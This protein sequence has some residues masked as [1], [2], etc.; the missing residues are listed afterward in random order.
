[1]ADAWRPTSALEERL[2]DAVA[3]GDQEGYFRALAGAELVVPVAPEVVDG[4]LGGGARPTWPTHE[5]DGRVYALVY[6][7]AAAMRAC[8]GDGYRHFLT[9]TFQDLAQS[10]P[11]NAWWLAVDVPA[12]SSPGVAPLPIEGRLPSWFVRQ[13]ADG[14][15]HPPQAGRPGLLARH[16]SPGAPDGTAPAQ[17][18]ASRPSEPGDTSAPSTPHAQGDPSPRPNPLAKAPPT[19]HAAHQARDDAAPH[20]R[21]RHTGEASS[22]GRNDA[23]G[24][25]PAVPQLGH[26][27]ASRATGMTQTGATPH[28]KGAPQPGRDES[29]PHETTAPG[30]PDTRPSD[31]HGTGATPLGSHGLAPRPHNASRPDQDDAAPSDPHGTSAT[32]QVS[33]ES[34]PHTQGAP[35]PD[36]DDAMPHGTG[37]TPLGSRGLAPHPQSAPRPGQDDAV[38]RGTGA[39]P[40]GSHAQGAP[41]DAALGGSRAGGG[42]GQNSLP[43]RDDASVDPRVSGGTPLDPRGV[44]HAQ[45][46]RD[47]DDARPDGGAALGSPGSDEAEPGAAPGVPGGSGSAGSDAWGARADEAP[48]GRGDAAPPDGFGVEPPRSAAPSPPAS[49][50]DGG[51]ASFPGLSSPFAQEPGAG[52]G[53][54]PP[55]VAEGSG[56]GF[57]ASG[58][59][60]RPEDAL[61]RRRDGAPA[62]EGPSNARPDE[63]FSYLPAE[64]PPP[65]AA[66]RPP[67]GAGVEP[68][69]PS[70]GGPAGAD[71]P[72]SPG[73]PPV[74]DGGHGRAFPTSDDAGQPPYTPDPRAGRT[75]EPTSEGPAPVAG[76]PSDAR[77]E[78]ARPAHDAPASSQSPAPHAGGTA[79][80]QPTSAAL[81]EHDAPAASQSLAPH[82]SGTAPALPPHGGAP[83]GEDRPP[84][85][86]GAHQPPAP[87]TI[88]P[89]S[90]ARPEGALPHGAAPA[91]RTPF[92][93]D[94]TPGSDTRA[95]AGLPPHGGA[96]GAPTPDARTGGPL[97]SHSGAPLSEGQA[98]STA[99]ARHEGAL[100][101]LDGVPAHED[102]APFAGD[103]SEAFTPSTDEPP[104]ARTE[105]AA[106][107]REGVPGRE[108][109]A[110][111]AAGPPEGFAPG[112]DEPSAAGTRPGGG[113]PPH[114]APAS[115]NRA[116]GLDEP[117]APHAQ[118]E[119]SLPPLDA[120][121][122]G[123]NGPSAPDTR[124]EGTLPPHSGTPA[125]DN[126]APEG[127]NNAL[128]PGLN[129]PSAPGTRT[130]SALPPRSG[131]T[132]APAPG[133]NEPTAP[134]TRTEGARPPHGGAP[135]S[136]NRA[137][138]GTNNAPVPGLSEPSAPDARTE[139]SLP[140]RSGTSSAPVP[141]LNEPSARDARTEGSLPPR[142]GASDASALG[143]S[144]PSAPDART[145]G[146]LPP[147]GGASDA[148]APHVSV[149]GAQAPYGASADAPGVG[150]AGP[151]GDDEAPWESVREQRAGRRAE[152]RAGFQAAND[153]ERALLAAAG[154]DD[155]DLFVQTL[156]DAEILLPVPEEMD[157]TLRPGRTGFPWR[158]V[159]VDGVRALPLYTSPERLVEAARAEGTG[160]E[161]LTLP[162]TNVLRYWPEPGLMLAVNSG[163]PAG[164]TILADQ[165]PGLAGW[166]DQ[167][168]ARRMAEAFDPQNDV[169]QRLFEAALRRD[170]DAFFKVLLGAQVLVPADPETPWGITPDDSE[171]PWRPVPVHGRPSIQVFT[172]LRWM[173]EAIGSSRFVMPSLLEI[174]TAW[175]DGGWTLVLNPGTPID[176]TLTA[177]QVRA[178][179]GPAP[180][181]PE[182]RPIETPQL[183]EQPFTPGNRIDQEL[184]E[185]ALGGDSDAFLRVLLA[186]NVLVPIP[187]DAPLEVTPV[188]GDF[189]WD[190]ALRDAGSVRVFTS[191]VRLRDVLPE[192][193]F[194]YADFRELIAA[195]PRDDWAMVLNPG[196]RIGASLEGEQVRALSAWAVRVGLVRARPEMTVPPSLETGPRPLPVE[197]RPAPDPYAGLPEPEGEPVAQP[198]IMQKVVPH[199]HV[200]WYLEQG[201]DRVGGFVHPTSDVAELQT[202]DQLYATLGLLSD[203][204]AFAPDDAAVHVI[205]WPAY[206]PAL[207]RV[208]FGGRSEADLAAWGEAGWVVEAAPF[209]GGGFAPGSAGTIREYKVDSVRLPYGAE[210]YVLGADRSERF[211]A[212]YDPDRLAWLR[213][214]GDGA[215]P[216]PDRSDATS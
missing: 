57:P 21:A 42:A 12:A 170:T 109:Q 195:W 126:R 175:P 54:P 73:E 118:A 135:A 46:G 210:M 106:P 122:P 71:R 183:P 51:G 155:H 142:G 78:G 95:E 166:A 48:A 26:A 100:P 110:P 158:T 92:A 29:T 187:D 8:L 171:F 182:P 1:M 7:S 204:A 146:A 197:E 213:P 177:D 70:Q 53:A 61:P 103:P 2:A 160:T 148:P 27:D 82:A 215:V 132:D 18:A 174:V 194:V 202:P 169:E 161:Y 87:G 200:G 203:G 22:S 64:G 185:A 138:G 25:D 5:E 32:P 11:D 147:R 134:D 163:S 88:E 34:A 72:Q 127:T 154:A 120:P 98:P 108:S 15:A 124:T 130:E 131:T 59:P 28:A 214:E 60:S 145:E 172:S 139:G 102:R 112:T 143:L 4:V 37:A 211:V 99:D 141:G 188:Q 63:G 66:G 33:H 149:E 167:R 39:T 144:E 153:V 67:Y 58:G 65:F 19:Q 207:Y 104:S 45:P 16:A 128:T 192:S 136:D 91:D 89:A 74:P 115:D 24:T 216:E 181:A 10:W 68:G 152:R 165:L 173:N 114:D 129:K 209:E 50:E 150:D 84:F 3:S 62:Q 52:P 80:G 117:S 205:R 196:T 23:P 178:L 40:L 6:T 81:P 193:R 97:S 38:P 176:A 157:Y 201:Y 14:D 123:L 189:R 85:A 111:F 208:P 113:L 43:G 159:E 180:T 55:F 140:P 79:P 101:P 133:L 20:D 162:F 35:R 184:H 119:G 191:L 168:T 137:P 206:C 47:V 44:P 56:P 77:P 186:A 107:P 198:T 86:G 13:L 75:Y 116:P 83:A 93:T 49:A 151:G 212:M 190:A 96:P 69:A 164:G 41:D 156:A 9:L 31:P 121:A 105:G 90:G 125:S 94:P 17:D 179:S 76:G 30:L 36:Q 199:E